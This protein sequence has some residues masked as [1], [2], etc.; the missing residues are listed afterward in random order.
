MSLHSRVYAS[1]VVLVVGVLL[2]G[3]TPWRVRRLCSLV[4]VDRRTVLRW[5][6]WW[7]DKL[8]RSRWYQALAGRFV[9]PPAGRRLPSSLMEALEPAGPETQLVRTLR[10]LLPLSVW[11]SAASRTVMGL[12]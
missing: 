4:G 11:G 3:P 7:Q 12:T 2:S 10:L 8:P 9:P 6:R 5:R 1:V